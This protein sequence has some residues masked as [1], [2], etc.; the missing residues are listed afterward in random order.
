L[1]TNPVFKIGEILLV[2]ISAFVFIRLMKPLVGDDPILKQAVVWVANILMLI[3]VWAGLK[4]RGEG[5][6]DFGLTFKSFPGER[7]LRC[8]CFLF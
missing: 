3:I 2:F 6:K 4:L 5:W 1:R 8:S 7:E